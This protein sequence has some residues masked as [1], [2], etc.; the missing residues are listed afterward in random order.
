M[1]DTAQPPPATSEPDGYIDKI[2]PGAI[3][4]WLRPTDAIPAGSIIQVRIDDG[5]ASLIDA[6]LY[7]Q[8][9]E[10]AG[11]AEA[12][13]GFH[14]PIPPS[15]HDGLEHSV[16]FHSLSGEALALMNPS[17]QLISHIITLP[18]HGTEATPE[19]EV[20]AE[21]RY[22]AIHVVLD[23][24]T[25][26]GVSGW[27]YSETDP[28]TPLSLDLNIDGLF[29]GSTLCSQRRDDVLQ[30]GYPTAIVGFAHPIPAMF[31]D[32]Q[33]HY[34]SFGSRPG[35]YVMLANADIYGPLGPR[36][37]FAP[38]RIVGQVDGLHGGAVRGWVFTHHLTTDT[39]IGGLQVLVTWQGQPVA[40]ITASQFRA[41]VGEAFKADPNCGF[42]FVAP[43]ELAARGRAELRFTVIPG[44]LE[45]TGSPYIAE[46]PSREA[47][48]R[49][50]QLTTLADQLFT[51]MWALRAEI[52]ALMPAEQHSL[53]NYDGW[54]RLYYAE[55]A[56][57]PMLALPRT[58]LVS[59]ICPAYRPRMSD[60]DAA[61]ASVRG[62]TYAN[63]ELIIV[64]DASQSAELDASIAAHV[65]SDRRIR[66]HR[67]EVNG[68][69]S[70]A[71]NTGLDL[72]QGEYVAFFDHDDLL[73]P[74]ALEFM[75]E[76]ALRT[77]ARL[78]YCDEDKIDDTGTYSEPNLKPDWNFR[79]L[80][81]IN[82]I[83]HL[84]VAERS[85]IEQV[86]LLRRECDGAQDHDFLIR[87]GEITPARQIHHVPEILYH[88][89]K[90]PQSTAS[91]GA[92]KPYT[93]AA[94]IRAISDHLARRGID[95]EVSSPLRITQFAITWKLHREPKVSILIPY[96][97]QI[98]MTTL[99]LDALRGLTTYANYE[100]VLMDNWSTS[101]E[102][103]AFAID[104]AA[105]P[106]TRVMRIEEKFN[107]S[108]I[109]NLAA[110][111]CDGEFL[112]F[113]NNDVVVSDPTWLTQLV[114]EA[115]ASSDIG[116]V[117]CKL[118]YPNG[119]IQHGGVVLGVGGV[120]DHAHRG[121][122][123][124]TPGY[125]AR[126]CMPQDMSAVTAACLLCR[127]EAFEGVG[128]FDEIQLQVAFNDV[129]L[130]LK[131][132]RAGYRVI[133]AAG[134]IAEHRESLSRGSDLKPE[135]QARFFHENKVMETRWGDL[136][137]HDPHYSRHFSRRGGVFADLRMIDVA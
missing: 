74:R 128:G 55:L 7:R 96:R 97:E 91:S 65:A 4:G 71:T 70:I 16:S 116:I 46:F 120:A 98:G 88:W 100:I 54:A 53:E 131:I 8:D 111:T 85:L 61:I 21:P 130:C 45:L 35:S 51:Q 126:A 81:A 30:A 31:F 27:A 114:G 89:R 106:N 93:V 72:V 101:D 33:P 80:L 25:E 1:T 63:W 67:C 32:G 17:T 122:T 50:M 38:T 109:N 52:K 121:L 77:G 6:S 39:R 49:V 108:R 58:P 86:G 22:E 20:P 135:H 76:A 28:L 41:D 136:L 95:A 127:R 3:I 29:C 78:L 5:P 83:C 103:L 113:L 90:T 123:V 134:I 15:F 19:P 66:S 64:D 73:Q 59:I 102:A 115:M 57:R 60:F 24:I 104:Q 92:V 137:A 43:A 124:N 117:G 2:D 47:Y 129:D 10:Q 118:H 44:G 87:L 14:F 110:A 23:G 105:I 132:G 12:N 18:P 82:Y 62:Q 9:V 79:Y 112:L 99:C 75:I 48:R 125:V 11:F 36:F 42:A 119:L 56:A 37:T 69:I 133:Y 40:Q 84:V 94:G 26:D 13:V 107:Y 34:V 68:G